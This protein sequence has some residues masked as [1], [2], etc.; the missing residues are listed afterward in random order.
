MKLEIFAKRYVV[1]E[2]EFLD[3]AKPILKEEYGPYLSKRRAEGVMETLIEDRLGD[4]WQRSEKNN[5]L[6]KGKCSIQYSIKN[7]RDK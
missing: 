3:E 7:L 2:S 4:G 5:H 6:S 1:T